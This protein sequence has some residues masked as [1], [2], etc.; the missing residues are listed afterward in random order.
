M[1]V[2][3]NVTVVGAT[4][5][6]GK[7]ILDALIESKKFNVTVLS[8]ESS[9]A[10]F[11]SSVKVTQADYSSV[12]SLTAALKGQDAVVSAV[13][14]EGLVGQSTIIDAAIAAGVKRFLPSEFGSNLANPK[15][16]ALPVFGHKVATRNHIE[17]K[18]KNGADLTYTYVI[19]G[20]FLDWGLDMGFI[21]DTKEG[22]PRIYDGGDRL[23][24]MTALPSIGLAVVGVLSKYEETKNKSVFVQNIQISQN[25]LLELAQK[26]APEKKWEPVPVNTVDILQS[27]N[28]ALGKGDFSMN[29]MYG[30]LFVGIFGEGYGSRFEKDDNAVLGVP[31][32]TEADVEALLK[33]L[34]V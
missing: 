22:K 2:I 33:K 21:F 6:V 12:E 9:T 20:P 13:G 29:V 28:D 27:S 23:I 10:T 18:V 19:T 7:P 17:E 1:V 11:P 8:R 16:A 14:T 34:L 5:A 31:R 26:I 24:S 3:K 32:K 25:K 15:T 30:Y 4:G